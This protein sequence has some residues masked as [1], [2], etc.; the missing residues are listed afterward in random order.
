MEGDTW[1]VRLEF[2]LLFHLRHVVENMHWDP[3]ITAGAGVIYYGDALNSGRDDFMLCGGAGLFYHFD[4]EWA[5]RMDG[6]GVIAGTDTEVNWLFSGGVNWRWGTSLPVVY[7][8]Q[9]G[10][11]DSDGDGLFDAFE[12][13]L[14]TDPYDPDTDDDGLLD[15]EE[16]NNIHT[17]PLNPDTDW[18]ALKDGAE[19]LT[20]ETDPL[21]PDTDN[22]GVMDGH[23][24]IEDHTDPLNG[25]DDL[26]LYTLNIEFDYDKADIRPIY[27]DE[28][29]MIVKVLLRDPGSTARVE[30]HADNRKKSSRP[31]NIRL[32]DRRARAIKNYLVDV[33]GIESARL[34]HKGYGFDRPIAP[35]DTEVNMQKNRRTEVYISPSGQVGAEDE[36]IEET[37][38][39]E[40]D[41]E[42]PVDTLDQAPV[43]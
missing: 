42:M 25:A 27:Y 8:V 3:Y 28:L 2:D 12:V 36:V 41:E 10:E 1:A 21:E 37:Y 24:V 20:Y 30:G 9:G 31:Y 5:I 4:D 17:D 26:Q 11:I 19:V 43:K 22:G 13:E 29:D 33:G 39:L 32:S 6:R 23:E 14:G 38:I 40:V 35:N 7:E 34:R 16:V 18:D 15:G